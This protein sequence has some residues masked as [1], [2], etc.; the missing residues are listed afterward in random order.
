MRRSDEFLLSSYVFSILCIMSVSFRSYIQ[1][2]TYNRRSSIYELKSEPFHLPEISVRETIQ[3]K[4][5]TRISE[6]I[7]LLLTAKIARADTN[8]GE[9]LYGNSLLL[10]Y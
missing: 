2:Q 7:I 1:Q 4:V 6:V 3:R 9:V 5:G 10:A 8:S